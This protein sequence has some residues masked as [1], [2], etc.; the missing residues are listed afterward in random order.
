M[1]A[2]MA[3]VAG[4][5]VVAVVYVIVVVVVVVVVVFAVAVIIFVCFFGYCLPY[6]QSSKLLV[7]DC[8]QIGKVPSLG[9]WRPYSNVTYSV[10]ACLM[11]LVLSLS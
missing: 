8:T 2:T 4:V 5:V 3:G 9:L 11:L 1:P 7:A 6:H 10:V